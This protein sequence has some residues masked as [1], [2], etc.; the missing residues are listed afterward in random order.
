MLR[1]LLEKGKFNSRRLKAEGYADTLPIVPNISEKIDKKIEE[2]SFIS[3]VLTCNLIL[4]K[5]KSY[6]KK[7][8]SNIY[9]MSKTI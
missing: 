9:A 7:I 2:L 4:K 5:Y 3:T 6:S 8:K 1:Y